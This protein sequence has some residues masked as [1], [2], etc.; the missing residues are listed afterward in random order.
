M[1][2]RPLPRCLSR[3]A[4]QDHSQS[5]WTVATENNVS[6]LSLRNCSWVFG[7]SHFRTAGCRQPRRGGLGPPAVLAQAKPPWLWA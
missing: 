1:Q 2:P 6:S 7:P 5:P 3:Q 4:R